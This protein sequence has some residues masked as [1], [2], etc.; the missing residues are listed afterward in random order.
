MTKVKKNLEMDIAML[1]LGF[2]PAKMDDKMKEVVF[3][4]PKKA[5]KVKITA[6]IQRRIDSA[7]SQI[8]RNQWSSWSGH[9]RIAEDLTALYHL[10]EG[11]S[12]T[13]TNPR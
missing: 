7:L 5:L 4:F 11:E 8:P 13:D 9:A 6:G 2:D 1:K 3:H 12:G 10:A